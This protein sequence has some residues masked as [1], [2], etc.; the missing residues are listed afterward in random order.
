MVSY[1]FNSPCISGKFVSSVLP[2]LRR[3]VH[4]PCALIP[5]HILEQKLIL[6]DSSY[7]KRTGHMVS[8]YAIASSSVFPNVPLLAEDMDCTLNPRC[9]P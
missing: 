8:Y 6:I 4:T 1:S 3:Q 5:N 9:V 7:A 2:N